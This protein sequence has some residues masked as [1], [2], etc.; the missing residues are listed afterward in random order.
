M[1]F[2]AQLVT[3]FG[4]FFVVLASKIHPEATAE[5]LFDFLALWDKE[6]D[7]ALSDAFREAFR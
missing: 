3:I 2:L 4:L 5:V 7:G 6:M 1:R